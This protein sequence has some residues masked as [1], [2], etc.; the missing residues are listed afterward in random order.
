VSGLFK[1]HQHFYVTLLK[2]KYVNQE[3]KITRN[4]TVFSQTWC[5]WML[6][7]QRRRRVFIV[8]IICHSRPDS[9]Y[10]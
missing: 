7:H 6:W 9:E 10:L 1:Q 5:C 4:K 8:H 2:S 3:C